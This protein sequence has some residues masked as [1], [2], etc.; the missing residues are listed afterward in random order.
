MIL[1]VRNVTKT[2]QVGDEE[3]HVLKGVNLDI[4]KGEFVSITGPSG[5][6]KSTLMHIIGLLDNPTSGQVI[7]ED[8]DVAKMSESQLAK[9]RNKHIGF[10][11]QQY[12]LL[13]RTSALENV[14]L[15]MFYGRVP[16]KEREARAKELLDLVGLSE[17]MGHK[18]N[19]LSGGQQQRVAIARA[20][21]MKPLILLADEPTGNLDSKTGEEIIKLFHDLNNKGNTIVLVT[22]DQNVARQAKRIIRIKDGLVEK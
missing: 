14:E 9:V 15:P 20:L 18:P 21:A 4:K 11:F 10:V 8:E 12:N 3:L 6:G 7:L 16:V 22:H 2:Y 5:S 19:Q 13:S 17:R 1:S